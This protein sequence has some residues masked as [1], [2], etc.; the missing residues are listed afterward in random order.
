L[1]GETSLVW[2]LSKRNLEV[3]FP[4]KS[5]SDVRFFE[6]KGHSLSVAPEP[7]AVWNKKLEGLENYGLKNLKIF[8]EDMYPAALEPIFGFFL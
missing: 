2:V 4:K 5:L 6:E 7:L 1:P 8:P 3:V